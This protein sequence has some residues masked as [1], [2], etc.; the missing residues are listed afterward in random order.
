MVPER[1]DLPVG[2]GGA[3]LEVPET[4]VPGAGRRRVVRGQGLVRKKGAGRVA[5]VVRGAAVLN[6]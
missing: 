2:T 1:R 5:R 6:R 4:A 3:S